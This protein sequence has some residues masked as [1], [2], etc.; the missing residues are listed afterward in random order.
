MSM[1]VKPGYVNPLTMLRNQ[2]SH[3]GE[4]QGAYG[5]QKDTKDKVKELQIKQQQLQSEMLLMKGTGSDSGTDSVTKLEKME[6]KLDEVTHELRT[7]KNDYYEKG[8]GH[9]ASAGVYE[10]KEKDGHRLVQMKR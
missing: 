6:S 7:A 9:K 3:A 2:G 10:V 4:S 1:Q 8:E 5:M